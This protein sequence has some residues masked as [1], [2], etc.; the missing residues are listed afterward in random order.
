[1]ARPRFPVLLAL[2]GLMAAGCA[3]QSNGLPRGAGSALAASTAAAP[4]AQGPVG[5]FERGA[6][7]AGR[8]L[9]PA[10]QGPRIAVLE[11]IRGSLVTVPDVRVRVAV[12]D[13]NGVTSVT[14]GRIAA[15]P[16]GGD[17]WEARVTLTPGINFIEVEARDGK[18]Q[19][20]RGCFSLAYGSFHSKD[21][22]LERAVTASFRNSGIA[23]AV[24]VLEG[25]AKNLQVEPIVLAHNPVYD[26]LL[27]RAEARAVRHGAP[28]M[29]L[30]GVSGGARVTFV[31]PSLEVD[32]GIK[33][34]GISTSATLSASRLVAIGILGATAAPP[35][36]TQTALG[37]EVHDVRVEFEDFQIRSSGRL[38]HSLLQLLD[39]K[40]REAVREKLQDLLAHEMIKAL[41]TDLIGIDRPLTIAMDVP[42]VGPTTL[43]M[44]FRVSDADG[45]PTT[46]LGISMGLELDAPQPA[47]SGAPTQFLVSG[48]QTLPAVTATEDAAVFVSTD[49]ANAFLHSFWVAGGMSLTVDGASPG[50]GQT[51]MTAGMLYPFFPAVRDLAPDP[52][53]PLRME[54]SAA[55]APVV[56]FGRNGSAV[57]FTAGE[58]EVT[59]MLDYMDNDPPAELF[60]LRIPMKVEGDLIVHGR[61]L[62]VT[63]LRCAR[64]AVDLLREPLIDLPDEEIERFM[65]AITP[66]LL[67]RFQYNVPPVPIPALPF[68]LDL[69]QAWIEAGGDLLAIRGNLR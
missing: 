36:P 41:G 22:F 28:E 19:R 17:R 31:L 47:V 40:V 12:S 32:L 2:T 15:A 58:V 21:A 9:D 14:I 53:T 37:L 63:D 5:P 48:V 67:E 69:D 23:K 49:A 42:V 33:A 29:D 4:A 44:R 46:G 68:G 61:A 57:E 66:V 51:F 27:A 60:T 64:I 35:Q 45:S 20:S 26:S 11:P 18:D 62:H 8:V 39:G 10:T 3:E 16:I 65:V 38:T 50:P 59:C 34:V 30:A 25:L 13:P 6:V 7:G 24:P 43:D 56:A 1:M 55:A 54:V 52:A